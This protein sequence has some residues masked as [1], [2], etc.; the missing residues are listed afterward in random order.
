MPPLREATIGTR[1][2]A[3]STQTRPAGSSQIDGTTS[4]WAVSSSAAIP[5]G[6]SS[7]RISMF[8]AMFNATAS[9]A[10]L[11]STLPSI[12]PATISEAS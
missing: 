7:P 4:A 6:P 3:A 11:G 12:G 9:S 5:S 10:K 8:A 1:A 2:S